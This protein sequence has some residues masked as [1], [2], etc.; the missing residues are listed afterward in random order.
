MSG[1]AGK[2]NHYLHYDLRTMRIANPRAMEYSPEF[3]D[4]YRWRFGID[5]TFSE[6]RQKDGAQTTKGSEVCSLWPIMLA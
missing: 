4:K 3:K 1:Q 2:K 5:T 6:I